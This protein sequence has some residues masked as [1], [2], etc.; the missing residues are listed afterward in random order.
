MNRPASLAWFASHELSLAWRDWLFMAA[1]GKAGR[2]KRAAAVFIL[3]AAFLHLVAYG[4]VARFA[5][6]GIAPDKATLVAVTGSAVLS[7]SLML[8]QALELTARAFYARGDFELILS[9]PAPARKVFAVRI[10]AIALSTGLMAALIAGPFINILAA[11]GGPHWLAAYG[12]LAAMA[13][14]AA[15]LG[16]ALMIA[17]FRIVGPR[18]TRLLAQIVAAVIGA[19]FVIG[20]QAAAILSYGSLSRW[21]VLQS[22]ALIARAPA[23]DSPLWW[24]ARAMMGDTAALLFV[25]AVSS[26]LL[27]VAVAV[28]A[29]DFG[30]LALAAA[31]AAQGAARRRR[32]KSKFRA[33]TARQVLRRKEWALLRRDPWLLSQSLM[34][35][36]YLLPPALLLWRNFGAG[37]GSLVMI[38]PVL[39]MAAGQLAGG[40]AWLAVSGEDAPDLVRTAP[41]PAKLIVR[42]K[43]EAVL[44]AVGMA[45]APFLLAL[46]FASPRIA[47]TTAAGIA[48]AAVSATAIQLWFRSQANR[49]HF[50]RRQISSRIATFAEAFSSITWAA[51]FALAAAGTWFAIAPALIALMILAGARA[52]RPDRR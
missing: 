19:G 44:I 33:G 36:L 18:Q 10:A 1:G 27:A 35:V 21:T 7:W 43:V 14:S 42:A 46:L 4:L 48:V 51:S 30:R 5:E 11:W 28:F 41:V 32:Q 22:E 31:G 38:V 15:A 3:F 45:F 50:R 49:S 47:V 20:V 29:P 16:L 24:P 12:V 23:P 52:M 6:R 13:A 8:S 34:Q 39:V 26:L 2:E 9:S 25:L 17:L 40:L 37:G